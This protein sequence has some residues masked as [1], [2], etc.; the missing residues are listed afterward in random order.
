MITDKTGG[1]R[2]SAVFVT[3]PPDELLR[4]RA[5]SEDVGRPM[6]WVVRDALR[7]Y[8]DAM[9][10]PAQELAARA[11]ADAMAAIAQD[12]PPRVHALAGRPAGSKGRKTKTRG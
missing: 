6:S 5:F 4:L 1:R 10:G 3:I 12:G 9:E 2:N 11:T 8:L 7:L